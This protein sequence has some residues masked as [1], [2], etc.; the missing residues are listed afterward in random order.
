MKRSLIFA[1]AA[2]A[3]LSAVAAIVFWP[4]RDP[5][6]HLCIAV[7]DAYS[8]APVSGAV[9]VFPKSLQTFTSDANG[10]VLAYSVPCDTGCGVLNPASPDYGECDFIVYAEGYLPCVWMKV[11]VYPSRMREGPSV[12]LFPKSSES[13]KVTV[14]SEAPADDVIERFVEKYAPSQ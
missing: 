9:I 13:V 3:V 11:H 10:R 7:A 1:A 6:G 12:F 5:R 14:F 2:A 4:A 8:Q